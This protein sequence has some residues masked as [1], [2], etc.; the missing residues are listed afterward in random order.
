MQGCTLP[1]TSTPRMYIYVADPT[2]ALCLLESG[3]GAG[4]AVVVVGGEGGGGHSCPVWAVDVG[5]GD[6]GK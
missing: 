4:S 1:R 3:Q 6:G 5:V 2:L